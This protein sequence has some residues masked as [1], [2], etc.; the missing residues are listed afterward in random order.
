ME[1]K[2]KI[3]IIVLVGLLFAIIVVAFSIQHKSNELMR[4]YNQAKEKLIQENGDI[5]CTVTYSDKGNNNNERTVIL[6][7]KIDKYDQMY[8]QYKENITLN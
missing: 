5:I 7:I 4:E 6:P 8:I 3:I 2:L 1:S